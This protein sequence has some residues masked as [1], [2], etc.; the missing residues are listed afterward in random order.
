[1]KTRTDD[2]RELCRKLKP[3]IGK[4][5]DM[6]WYY[7]LAADEKSRKEIEKQIEIISEKHL[8]KIPLQQEPI[9]LSPPP[10]TKTAGLFYLGNIFYNNRQLYPLYLAPEDFIKQIGIF[11]ITGEGKTNTAFL[12]ALEL[13]KF[14]TPF[15]VIDWKRGWRNLLS[16]KDKLP[17]LDLPFD[18]PFKLEDVKVYTIGRDICPF[19]WNPFRPPP[20]SDPVLWISTIAE[21]LEKSHVSGPGVASLLNKIY[22]SLFKKLKSHQDFYPNFYD[23]L[24]MINDM[25]VF[26]REL[27]WKQT[28]LR[29]LQSFTTGD[30]AKSF[31]ARNPV[32]L[33]ELLDKP[34]IFELD[35][36]MPKALR[37][38]FT[39]I[40]LRWIHLYRLSQGETDKLRHVLFLEEVHN[41]FPKTRIE[42][43]NTSGLE[44]IYRELR[45]FGQGLVSI[46]QHP[47]LLPVYILGNCHGLIFLGLQHEADIKAARQSLFLKWEQENY[48]SQLNTGEA[49]VR[50][51]NRIDPCLVKI[52]LVRIDKGIIDDNALKTRMQGY[53]PDLPAE[54]AK[55]SVSDGIYQPDNTQEVKG[56]YDGFEEKLLTDIFESPVSSITQRYKRLNIN[57]KYGNKY[58]NHLVENE[59]IVPARIITRKGIVVL[60]Q[61]TQ[62]GKAVLREKGISIGAKQEGIEHKFWK[63]KIAEYYKNMGYEV[64][65]EKEVNG[66]PDIIVNTEKRTA[67]EIETGNSD[68]L[69]NIRRCMDTGFEEIVVVFTNKDAEKKIK[70]II[71]TKNLLSRVKLTSV[72]S[73]DI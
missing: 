42:K 14:R 68:I 13:L 9:L 62:K 8:N 41:L 66:S 73:F 20:G 72:L 32:K 55:F 34:V 21:V 16:Y 46:T 15:M 69:G 25:K 54:M 29:I 59:I 51:K 30:I 43:E 3:V 10:V 52:P 64:L 67:I 7:Y 31:N 61:I 38:F 65:V 47:S 12:L 26:A 4:Q 63:Y 56:K 33:E 44:N 17:G 37:T 27:N 39:E 60:F 5:A 50:I 19:S 71:E 58:K 40:M 35:L 24:A 2:I 22:S 70:N 36:E 48:F 45:G 1:M 57:P 49:I 23:G 11:S 28:A 18:N 53:L 6:L